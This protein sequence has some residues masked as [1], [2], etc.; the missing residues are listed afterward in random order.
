[1]AV[2]SAGTVN[3][4]SKKP[5]PAPQALRP[6]STFHC[7]CDH[8]AFANLSGA[9]ETVFAFAA[10]RV[11]KHAK[12]RATTSGPSNSE[13]HTTP[14]AVSA[15][16][17]TGTLARLPFCHGAATNARSSVGIGRCSSLPSAFQKRSVAESLSRWPA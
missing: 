13:K 16:S 15:G 1:M 17:F 4:Y 5:L 10:P 7:F 11:T 2:A 9:T 6:F 8:C 12:L 3:A 14:H